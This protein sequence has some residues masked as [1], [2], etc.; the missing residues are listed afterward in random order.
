MCVIVHNVWNPVCPV[1]LRQQ[2]GIEETTRPPALHPPTHPT[3]LYTTSPFNVLAS[4][5]WRF[6]W[7]GHARAHELAYGIE[8]ARRQRR[9]GINNRED[10]GNCVALKYNARTNPPTHTL[11]KTVALPSRTCVYVCRCAFHRHGPLPALVQYAANGRPPPPP[12]HLT[13]VCVCA[14]WH[15]NQTS[16]SVRTSV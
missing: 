11:K 5:Q 4:K 10:P 2:R 14:D 1:R 9:H 7:T 8:L 15:S 13:G 3:H 12:P 6:V 16:T